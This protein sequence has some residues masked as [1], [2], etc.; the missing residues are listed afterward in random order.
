MRSRFI[1]R[2]LVVSLLLTIF[3]SSCATTYKRVRP[4]KGKVELESVQTEIPE[5]LLLDVRIQTF[6]LGE[7]P[8]SENESRG[9]SKEIRQAES[10]YMA[11]QL[12]H[13][14][15][16]TGY[17]GSVRVVPA[18]SSGDEVRVIG[19][20]L[21]SNG[22]E[23]KLKIEAFDAAGR[24]WFEKDFKGAVN[25]Q[26]YK[27]SSG[28][29]IEVFQNVYYQI[30]N[31]L[32]AY[33][34]TMTRDQILE[35]R[36]VSEMRFAKGLVPSAFNGYLQK[37]EKTGQFIIDRLPSEDDEMLSR[38]RRVRERDY[39]LVDTLDLNYEGLH[40]EM[41][42]VYTNWRKSRLQEMNLIREVDAAKNKEMLKG[43]LLVLSGA[44]LGV[45]Y[46]QSEGYNPALPAVIGA[47]VGAGVA[48]I[49]EADKIKEEAE[50][51]K[52]ALEELGVSFA[53]E[54]EPTVLKVEGETIELTGSAEA[55]YEQWREVLGKLYQIETGTEDVYEVEPREN[56][57]EP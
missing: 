53:A 27:E 39:M 38:V 30:A 40:R 33:Y 22:E 54:V 51:N 20:I 35:V 49:F 55:K 52:A 4:D 8:S 44:A 7:L 34:K 41:R 2:G 50:I 42:E 3:L 6:D 14:L 57:Q 47:A 31:E 32:A 29:Q 5:P 10:K 36:Q 43:G 11:V 26:M 19:R 45:L 16:Q 21:K 12:K 37:N 9:I 1:L 15:Y 46:A 24:Q 25:E 18:E 17:W 56:D 48:K 28:K 13:A 23:L